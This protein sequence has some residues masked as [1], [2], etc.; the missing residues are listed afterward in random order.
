LCILF[1]CEIINFKLITSILDDDDDDDDD[2]DEKEEDES[3]GSG[4]EFKPGMSKAKKKTTKAKKPKE[5]AKP[6]KEVKAKEKSNK[7][8]KPKEKKGEKKP[9]PTKNKIESDDGNS[10]E[11]EPLVK[12]DKKSKPPTDE[13]LRTFIKKL[14]S[15]ANLE[16]VTMKTVYKQ[17]YE[18]HPGFDLTPRKD[19]IKETVKDIIR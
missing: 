17:V 6:S 16:E 5:K 18:A 7:E 4:D 14:L 13:E 10:S 15:G 11:D 2:D 8:V 1:C 12:V 3:D 19:F 9:A